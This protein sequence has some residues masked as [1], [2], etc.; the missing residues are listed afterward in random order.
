LNWFEPE[1]GG[2]FGLVLRQTASVPKHGNV[3]E[4]GQIM[5]EP[6]VGT[7]QFCRTLARCVG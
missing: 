5:E 2:S 3:R 7:R 4:S 6:P 1:C